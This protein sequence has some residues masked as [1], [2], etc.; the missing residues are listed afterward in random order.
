MFSVKKVDSV[1]NVDVVDLIRLFSTI[2]S[3]SVNVATN[4]GALVVVTEVLST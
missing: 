1:S 4:V 3:I 2:V